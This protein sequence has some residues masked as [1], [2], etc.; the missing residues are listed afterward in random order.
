MSETQTIFQVSILAAYIA[1]MVALFAPCCISYLFPAYLG[2]IFKEKKQVLLMTFIYSLG[3]FVVMLP[4]V[5]GAKALQSLF[6]ELHDQTY[7]VGGVFMLFVA[8]LSFLGIKLPMPHLAM[9]QSG[10]QKNDVIST[11]TLGVFSGI[12]SA[13]CAPVLIGVVALSSLSPTLMQSLAVGAA[14]VFGMVTPLYLASLFIH[15]RNILKNPLLKKVLWQ[16]KI[17]ETIY[18]IFV[19][20]I[21]AT[22]IFGV[23]G[24]LMLYLTSIGRLGMS[25]AEAQVTQNINNVALNISSLVNSM[26]YLDI[27]FT[28]VGVYL[29][30][31]YIRS[32]MNNKNNNN[33]DMNKEEI[34]YYCPMHKDVVSDKPGKCPKCGEMDLVEVNKSQHHSQEHNHQ[35][36]NHEHGM[37]HHAHMASPQAAADFLNRFFIVTALLVPLFTFK[38]LDIGILQFVVAT[39]IFYFGFVFFQHA[40]HEIMSKQYGMM[41][42]VS[43]AISAGYLFSAA[44]TFLPALE[45]EFYLEIS[46]LIWVLLFGHYLEAKSSTAA[47]NALDEVAKLLPKQAL[48]LRSGKTEKV[49]IEDLREGDIVR[50]LAGEKVPA[51]GQIVKGSSNFNEAHISGESKPIEK[52]K[53]DQVV[54][55]AICVDGSVDVKLLRI[56]E[57]STI[58]QIKKLISEAGKTKPSAQKLADKAASWLTF[59]AISVALLTILT[60]LFILNSSIAF[61]M[62]LAIT[63]L[64]IACPHALGLAIPTVS[65]IATKLAVNNGLFIKDMAK[66]EV[67]KKANYIVFDKTGTLTKGEF[68]VTEIIVADKKYDKNKILQIAASIESHSSHVIG[69]SI[70]NYA[71]SK[72][73]KIKKVSNVKNIAGKGIEGKI[74]GKKYFVGKHRS[75]S[76]AIVSGNKLLGEIVLSDALKPESKKAIKELHNMDIKVAMLTGDS[77]KIAKDVSQKLQIDK[78]FAEVLPEDKYKHIKKLQSEGNIVLMVGDG[79]ND[80]PALTQANVGVAV[81]AGTDVAVEAGDVVLTSS[82]P[83]DIVAFIKLSRKVYAKMIQNLFWAL[84]YN[85]VAIPAAAGLFI[86]FGFRLTPSV[87]ALLMSLSSVIVVINAMT[88]R[89]AKLK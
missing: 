48:R 70:V 35:E 88:L 12:T 2:N 66:L 55:G 23:T 15:K 8:A 69:V 52:K 50:V 53:G 64:V 78:Y 21:I 61:A 84:G 46:T 47:G 24:V 65:T 82:N 31:K 36:H 58:G 29:L 76:V 85:V 43:V 6:F 19:S 67:A 79:V 1:G 7:L 4:I 41:T 73:V 54:A 30:Y 10:G 60:W 86:P 34:K 62:T 9:K 49:D 37:D 17:G 14:Y 26:P 63:V 59:I 20:N 38:F 45:A 57:D 18:P 89:K 44:S 56:G 39:I 13:C 27:V 28:I 83:E 32:I 71:K 77:E 16:I 72:K 11:F 51:D 68:G 80:A 40:R 74:G 22:L 87:G 42:L 75:A 81:G 3:I 5:L 33:G 25:A